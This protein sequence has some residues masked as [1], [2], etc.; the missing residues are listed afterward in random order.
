MNTLW[1]N[2]PI[3]ATI[4]CLAGFVVGLIVGA[5]GPA[6]QR[7]GGGNQ[8]RRS[9]GAARKDNRRPQRGG[10]GVELYIGNLSYDCGDKEVTKL[11]ERHG[12]VTSVRIITNRGNGRSKGYGFV[13]MANRDEATTAVRALNGKDVQGRHIVVNEAKSEA[14]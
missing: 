2:T 4:F 7:K 12:K 14:R 11:F 13:Q 3:I 1:E 8:K 9:S 10:A 6:R 5:N